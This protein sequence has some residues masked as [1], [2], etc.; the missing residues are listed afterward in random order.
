M[1]AAVIRPVLIAALAVVLLSVGAAIPTLAV[2]TQ[3]WEQ[4]RIATEAFDSAASS[5]E[6]AAAQSASAHAALETARDAA[7]ATLDDAKL[8]ASGAAGYFSAVVVSTLQ[9]AT[10]A[11]EAT[12]ATEAADGLA[13]PDTER[14][15]SIADLEAAVEPLTAWAADEA[16]R[17]SVVAALAVE[18]DELSAAARAAAVALA[19]TVTAEA[20]AALGAAPL[21]SPESRSAVEKARD[22]V[23]AAIDDSLG[24]PVGAYA[25]A[26]AAL[27]ASQQAAV[28]AAAAAEAEVD[29]A[30]RRTLDPNNLP[31]LP[32]VCIGPPGEQVCF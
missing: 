9:S 12:L 15:E 27:R 10:T 26:V 17:A 22:E 24:A 18:L 8:V 28:D 13:M 25:S 30:P 14:P 5:V 1:L 3:N 19:E 32:P 23:L 2:T 29:S 16:E 11:L 21:A 6:S 7:A 20:S 4:R 31:D